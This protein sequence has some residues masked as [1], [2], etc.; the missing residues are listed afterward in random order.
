MSTSRHSL[1]D[2]NKDLAAAVDDDKVH[3]GVADQLGPRIGLRSIEG[4]SHEACQ[5][6]AAQIR[7]NSSTWIR[8]DLL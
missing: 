2:N 1:I 5:K 3:S 4:V 8:W 7:P 6:D